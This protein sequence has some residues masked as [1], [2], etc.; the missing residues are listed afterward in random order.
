MK[1]LVTGGAGFIGSALVR[2]LVRSGTAEVMNLDKLTYAATLT[3]VAEVEALPGY[4]FIQADIADAAAI[5]AVFRE[6][7]P[8]MVVNLAAETH[9]DR[10]ITGAADFVRHNVVGTYN[11]KHLAD[12]GARILAASGPS[13]SQP[14]VRPFSA[15]ACLPRKTDESTIGSREG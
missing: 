8:D 7:R 2:R 10:S 14:D 13:P 1:I 9:V 3:S 12:A 15:P 5:A 6:Y 4:R 11:Q